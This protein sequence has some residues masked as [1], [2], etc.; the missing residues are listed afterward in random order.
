MESLR[1]WAGAGLTHLLAD[2]P[3]DLTGPRTAMQVE[4]LAAP[5]GP[6]ASSS[7]PAKGG[8]PQPPAPRPQAA[9]TNKT[10]QTPG[11]QGATVPAVSAF[12]SRDAVPADP[13]DW[14]SAWS[15]RFLKTSPAPVIWTYHELGL[16]LAGLS[17][18]STRGALFRKII[19][20]LNLPRGSSAFWPCALPDPAAHNLLRSN[21]A[22]FAAGLARLAPRVLIV[23]GK[24]ALAD[25]GLGDAAL[26][27][28]NQLM[29]EGKLVVSVPDT[30]DLSRN[31]A[32][33]ATTVSFLLAMLHP[34]AL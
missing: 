9:S 22:L 6:S 2:G 15:E 26:A 17:G 30:A 14:P 33:A 21:P 4:P 7:G 24:K 34:L 28:F 19:A 25:I 29:V 32:Q 16:D 23:S 20:E 13:R 11:G 8:D 31:P 5:G 12:A 3:V 10:R 18:P 27:P 1:P